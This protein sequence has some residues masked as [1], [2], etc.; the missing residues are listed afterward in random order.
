VIKPLIDKI[1]PNTLRG[2]TQYQPCPAV[3]NTF[4]RYLFANQ[5]DSGSA[6]FSDTIFCGTLTHK[7]RSIW[8]TLDGFATKFI[9]IKEIQL[10]SPTN[11][12]LI[13]AILASGKDGFNYVLFGGEQDQTIVARATTWALPDLAQLPPDERDSLKTFREIW[14]EGEQLD[15]FEI[16]WSMDYGTTFTLPVQLR[17]TTVPTNDSARVQI[18]QEG[19]QIMIKLST[20]RRLPQAPS[21]DPLISYFKIYYEVTAQAQGGDF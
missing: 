16:S 8:S 13:N 10:Y 6:D 19:R 18:G 7:G 17:L 12:D 4:N 2:I 5:Q 15:Q 21:P 14:I 11:G 1:N 9:T 3:D 20:I